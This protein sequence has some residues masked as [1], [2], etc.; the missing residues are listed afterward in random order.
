M[1]ESW[2]ICTIILGAFPVWIPHF[3]GSEMPLHPYVEIETKLKNNPIKIQLPLKLGLK[4][5]TLL[6]ILKLLYSLIN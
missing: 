2:F 3:F 6:L 4:I 5:E 1:V